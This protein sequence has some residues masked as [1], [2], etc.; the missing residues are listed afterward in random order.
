[1]R[2]GVYKLTVTCRV[3]DLDDDNA[4]DALDAAL[5]VGLDA[6]RTL[7][8]VTVEETETDSRAEVS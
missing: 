1:M 4:M 7:P 5:G 2:P 3:P 6:A 8:G